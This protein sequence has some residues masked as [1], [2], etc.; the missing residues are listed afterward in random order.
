MVRGLFLEHCLEHCF[1]T[2]AAP[3]RFPEVILVP[4]EPQKRDL[5]LGIVLG[6]QLSKGVVFSAN[7]LFGTCL[8]KFGGFWSV[9]GLCFV[10]SEPA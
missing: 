2:N 8:Q 1:V 5:Q 3:F 6:L 9:L 10:T 4:F 7:Y